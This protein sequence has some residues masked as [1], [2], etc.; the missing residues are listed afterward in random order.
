MESTPLGWKR[1]VPVIYTVTLNPALDKEY[2][3]RQLEH[4]AV[5]RAEQVRVHPGGKGFNVSRM[6]L[7]LGVSSTALGLVGGETGRAIQRSLQALGVETAFSEIAGETRTNVSVVAAESGEHIKVNEPGPAVS[8]AD[9]AG[10]VAQV[11]ARARPGDW[12]VLAGSLPP[13]APVDLYAEII[14]RVQAAGGYALLDT[15]GPALH[16]GIAAQ[17]RLV[18]PNLAEVEQTLGRAVTSD[19]EVAAALPE[20][21][22]MG[23]GQVVVSAAGRGAWFGR[24]ERRWYQPAAVIAEGNPIGAGDALV[25]GL[26]WRLWAGDEPGEAL[27]WAVAC[28]SAAASL[29]GTEMPGL[30]QVCSLREQLPAGRRG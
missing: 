29:P 22:G 9:L 3:V 11:E 16:A 19:A 21:L 10:F 28:G 1:N 23:A 17:P 24:G 12:W 25:G 30:E 13:G 27:A 4:N 26:V 6:L 15:S 7:R 5:L 2:T 20:L 14:R 18:K 8:P